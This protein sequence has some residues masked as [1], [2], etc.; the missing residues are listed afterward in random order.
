MQLESDARPLLR[1]LDFQPVLYQGQPMWFLRD[2]LQ[3]SDQQLFMPEAIAPLLTLIDGRRTQMEIHSAFCQLVGTSLDP[4][5]TLE[6]IE[7]LNDALLLENERSQRALQV[8]LDEYRSQ[9]YRPPALA[10]N[11]YPADPEA[12]AEYLEG[13]AR[14]GATPAWHGRGLVSPHI[15]YARG[16]QV[17]SQVWAAAEASILEADLV[18]IF[19][20]DHYGGPGTVTLTKQAYATPYGALPADSEL[21]GRLAA[22]LGEDAAYAEELHHRSEHSVELSAV[23]LHHIFHKAGKEPCPVVPILV[24]SFHHFV[25][26]GRKPADDSRLNVFLETLQQ[27]TSGRHVLA[28][29]SV[30]LAHVGPNFG[31]EFVMDRLRRESLA[32]QDQQLIA[33]ALDGD[34]ESWYSQIAA[35][36]DRNRI[37]GFAPTY[38]MLRYLGKSNGLQIAYD[39]C[40]ADNQDTSL[41]SICG[42]LIE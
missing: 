3:L 40:T 2:P 36:G 34:A 23:W 38:L 22:A 30:D 9:A 42:L 35:V 41:V 33:A 26:N 14:G 13:F 10:G 8:R 11:G 4:A 12:L 28:V 32:E 21:V 31:D 29:A 24:G 7:R 16:G 5:V 20:T 19:G 15:D 18:L 27:E 37:C 17:Y 39:Q 25:M 1:P 6:A